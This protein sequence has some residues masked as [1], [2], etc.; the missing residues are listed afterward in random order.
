HEL[1]PAVRFT[2]PIFNQGQGLIARAD[3]DL[4]A[5]DRRRQTVHNQIVMDVRTAFARYQQTRAELDYLRQYTRK[6]AEGAFKRAELAYKE[7]S[8]AY[9]IVLETI[10]QFIDTAAREALLT[11]ALRRA[12]AELARSGGRRLR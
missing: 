9:L 7:G 2:I 3:A 6:E 12:W 8:V 1:G 5:I 10:G 4:E 11:A